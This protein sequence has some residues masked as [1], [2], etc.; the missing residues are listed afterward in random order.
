MIDRKDF[1]SYSEAGSENVD[2]GEMDAAP[3]GAAPVQASSKVSTV[4][5][6]AQHGQKVRAMLMARLGEEVFKSWFNALEFQ[7]F[8]G[9]VLKV[10]VPVKFLKSWIQTHYS[11]I[12]LECAGAEFKGVVRV[13]V[14]LRQPGGGVSRPAL[15]APMRPATDEAARGNSDARKPFGGRAPAGQGLAPRT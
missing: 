15:A 2:H 9:T 3:A 6:L 1:E 10:S 14:V 8:D 11:E 13:D 5:V 12:L 4:Q 7:T